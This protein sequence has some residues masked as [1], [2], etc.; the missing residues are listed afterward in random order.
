MKKPICLVCGRKILWHE[1]LFYNYLHQLTCLKCNSIMKHSITT[2]IVS[3]MLMIATLVL[4]SQALKDGFNY[5]YAIASLFFLIGL[6]VYLYNAK[7]I[8][9]FSNGR[10]VKNV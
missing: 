1:K 7:L 9:V 6:C 4:F 8:L 10:F 2:N 3:F 5:I